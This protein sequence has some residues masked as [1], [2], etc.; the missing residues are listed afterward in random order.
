VIS[1]LEGG[2]DVRDETNSLAKSIASHIDS[3]VEGVVEDQT[4]VIVKSEPS[5][6]KPRAHGGRLAQ[7][8]AQNIDDSSIILLDDDV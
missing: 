7:L 1:V 3:I 6:D 8:L 4:R 5:H 2:Y